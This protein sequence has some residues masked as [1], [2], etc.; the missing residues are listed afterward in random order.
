MN[1]RRVVV[2]TLGVVALAVGVTVAGDGPV[3]TVVGDVV[4]TLGNDYLLLAAIAGLGVAVAAAMLISGRST[5]LDRTTMPD[6]ERPTAAPVPGDDFDDMVGRLRFTLPLV[7]RSTR[8]TVRER[9]RTAATDAVR[10]S[11]RC[12]RAEAARRVAAGTWTDD[13]AASAFL[14]EGQSYGSVPAHVTAF[15]DGETLG[16][17]RVRRTVD[18]IAGRTRTGG[19]ER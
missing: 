16:Q 2:G 7:G 6:P 18:E 3:S 4:E 11:E 15:V 10:H 9:L 19:S 17:R 12:S 13:S 5:N 1:W 8:R 14:S